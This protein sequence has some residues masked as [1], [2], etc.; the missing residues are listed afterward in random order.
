MRSY[1]E[2]NLWLEDF[3]TKGNKPGCLNNITE[4][5][6]PKGKQMDYFVEKTVNFIK[7]PPVDPICYSSKSKASETK[8]NTEGT[9]NN[10]IMLEEESAA[11]RP[12]KKN[13][14]KSSTS[15]RTDCTPQPEKKKNRLE[16]ILSAA[17]SKTTRG[18]KDSAPKRISGPSRDAGFPSRH[19]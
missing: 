6:V 1:I 18:K 15:A 9:K 12:E 16:S 5:C 13:K 4:L 3:R 14:A 7:D 11:S 10:P 17:N 19:F 2:P 8:G